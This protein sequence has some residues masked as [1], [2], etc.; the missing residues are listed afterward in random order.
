MHMTKV[1]DSLKQITRKDDAK[2]K[3]VRGI[4]ESEAPT[5]LSE[6]PRFRLAGKSG[7]L[8][9]ILAVIVLGALILAG[10]TYFAGGEDQTPPPADTTAEPPG[11]SPP[12]AVQQENRAPG[13]SGAVQPPPNAVTGK[14]AAPAPVEPETAAAEPIA[15]T[16]REAG[17]EAAKSEAQEAQEEDEPEPAETSTEPTQ[18]TTQAEPDQQAEQAEPA[19]PTA[20]SDMAETP[21]IPGRYPEASLRKLDP[22]D[23]QGM[24][25]RELR[26][27][28]NEIYARHGYRFNS[29]EMQDHF[30]DTDWYE[31]SRD[32]VLDRLSEVEKHNIELIREYE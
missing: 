22:A 25:S 31:P 28:R 20:P 23:L 24:T 17:T 27:M 16:E 8:V 12:A 19:E 14:V 11:M 2:P 30:G 3:L 4:P 21:D 15:K 1:F 5:R 6:G 13:A 10:V 7:A 29:Q 32:N 18:Q 26:I 9:L